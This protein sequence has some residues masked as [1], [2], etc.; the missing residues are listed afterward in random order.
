AAGAGT[1]APVTVEFSYDDGRTWRKATC[2]HDG[3]FALS[4]PKQARFV[5]LRATARDSAGNT[6]TQSVIRAF[7]LR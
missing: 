5:S 6:V 2:G 7:G 3:R 4:A 1:I